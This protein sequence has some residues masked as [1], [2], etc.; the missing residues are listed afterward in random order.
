MY[1]GEYDSGSLRAPLGDTPY[2]MDTIITEHCTGK[3]DLLDMGCGTCRKIL[4]LVDKCNRIVGIDLSTS[5]VAKAQSKIHAI[6]N[7]HVYLMNSTYTSFASQSFDIV[8]CMLSSFF[9]A[10]VYRVLKPGGRF[11]WECLGADD[12]RDFKTYF[13]KDSAGWRGILLEE[14]NVSRIDNIRRMLDGLFANVEITEHRWTT[15]LNYEGV[16]LLL[17]QTSTIRGIET[18]LNQIEGAFRELSDSDG[19]VKVQEHRYVVTG[20]AR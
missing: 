10:E 11:F 16:M 9:P 8:T 18:D 3:E 15:R 1:T 5:M 17:Q 14:N 19:W 12:K 2:T 7:F 6:P 20:I 13:G 4:S